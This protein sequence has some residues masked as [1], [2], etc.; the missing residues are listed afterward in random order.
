M[1]SRTSTINTAQITRNICVHRNSSIR[2]MVF[3][4]TSEWSTK[5]APSHEGIFQALN[6]P[7]NESVIPK[8]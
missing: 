5:L 6:S 3:M 1:P 4:R 8:I 7:P 2:R